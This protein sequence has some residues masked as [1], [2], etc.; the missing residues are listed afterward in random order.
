MTR[1]EF[2]T[3]FGGAAATWPLAAQGQQVPVVGI[4]TF[5]PEQGQGGPMEQ[6]FAALRRGLGE[7]GFIDGRNVALTFRSADYQYDRFPALAADLG[8]KTG[9]VHKREILRPEME[10]QSSEPNGLSLIRRIGSG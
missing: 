7:T 1:R 10:V 4:L 6:V 5:V 3:V 9:R 2:I 8:Q